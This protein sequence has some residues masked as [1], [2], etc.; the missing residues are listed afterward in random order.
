L[1]TQ[2]EER[3][4]QKKKREKELHRL[5]VGRHIKPLV[6]LPPFPIDL[7]KMKI[8]NRKLLASLN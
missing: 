7:V 4:F 2:I 1:R 8:R 5:K 3:E 6:E